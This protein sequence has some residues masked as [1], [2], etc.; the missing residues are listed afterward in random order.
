MERAADAMS[1]LRMLSTQLDSQ[2]KKS[3]ST[4]ACPNADAR[5][6]SIPWSAAATDQL[7]RTIGKASASVI[8]DYDQ[9]LLDAIKG[10]P[11]VSCQIK[12]S[13]RTVL[14][15]SQLRAISAVAA[16]CSQPLTLRS[17]GRLESQ[18]VP[19]FQTSFMHS[20]CELLCDLDLSP[21]VEH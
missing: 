21:G 17:L 13:V 5:S 15:P 2:T 18:C 19:V 12:P 9:R 1:S 10:T 16:P 4:G 7:F 8:E 11:F 14:T 6:N 20:S 3:L